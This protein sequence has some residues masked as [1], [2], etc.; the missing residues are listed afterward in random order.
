M[1]VL[2][3][4]L[5]ARASILDILAR[6]TY[7]FMFSP[8]FLLQAS[9]TRI[10]LISIYDSLRHVLQR[11]YRR[12]AL[13]AVLAAWENAIVAVAKKRFSIVNQLR[14]K[15]LSNAL[16]TSVMGLEPQRPRPWRQ[17]QSKAEL[18]GIGSQ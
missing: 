4:L 15:H 7:R 16:P 8:P 9:G 10:V 5:F 18:S 1:F 2:L 13:R 3:G 6:P 12:H 14:S 11:L 17:R